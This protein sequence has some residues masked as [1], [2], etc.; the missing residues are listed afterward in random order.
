MW[1]RESRVSSHGLYIESRY[2]YF[3]R[4]YSYVLPVLHR[5]LLDTTIALSAEQ[6][7][8]LILE[9]RT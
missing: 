7:R 2:W 9:T 3:A 8:R 6:W 1:H 5:I 4:A